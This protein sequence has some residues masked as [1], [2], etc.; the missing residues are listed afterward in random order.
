MIRSSSHPH[1]TSSLTADHRQ[2]ANTI[3]TLERAIEWYL[4]AMELRPHEV[5]PV[6][7]TLRDSLRIMIA[8]VFDPMYSNVM[9]SYNLQN[10]QLSV[11]V[12]IR[13]SIISDFKTLFMVFDLGP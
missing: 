3:K 6:L 8:E 5:P 2:D 10:Q 1:W 12:E 7:G 11:D 13:L 9:L 4:K